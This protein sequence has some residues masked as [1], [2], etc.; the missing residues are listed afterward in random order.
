MKFCYYRF[1]IGEYLLWDFSKAWLK[2]SSL[3]FILV[4]HHYHLT[5]ENWDNSLKDLELYF[6]DVWM[7]AYTISLKLNA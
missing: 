4:N 2:F 5:L 7:Q 6:S 3:Y 1:I